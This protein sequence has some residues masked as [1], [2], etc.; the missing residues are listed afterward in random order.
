MKQYIIVS[1]MRKNKKYSVMKYNKEKKEYDYLLS[2]GD[3]R[4]QQFKDKTPLKLWSNLDH[5][6]LNRKYLYYKRHPITDN[7]ESASYWS[8]K[9]LW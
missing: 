8:N 3:S 4:Y 6:D 5:G 2:F 1:P 9:Y 7:K